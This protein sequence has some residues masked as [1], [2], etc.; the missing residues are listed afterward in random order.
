M[1]R[2]IVIFLARKVHW[3]LFKQCLFTAFQRHWEKKTTIHFSTLWLLQLC[4]LMVSFSILH[5]T[6]ER[7]RDENK[8]KINAN[9]EH[10]THNNVT[11]ADGCQSRRRWHIHGAYLHLAY[12]NEWAIVFVTALLCISFTGAFNNTDNNDRRWR[13]QS[14]SFSLDR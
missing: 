13:K 8:T 7:R 4:H 9:T 14:I 2:S 1:H 3:D 12:K 5:P 10:T 11:I 6:I